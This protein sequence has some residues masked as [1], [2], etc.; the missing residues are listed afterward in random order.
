MNKFKA[1]RKQKKMSQIDVA[2]ALNVHQTTVSQWELGKAY[3]DIATLKAVAKLYDT[4]VN[5]LIDDDGYS[6]T[7]EFQDYSQQDKVQIPIYGTIPAGPPTEAE[8]YIIEYIEIPA[9]WQKGG[10]EYFGL[11][12]RGDSMYPQFIEGDIVILRRQ[13]N[14]EQ[15]KPHAVYVNGYNATLKKVTISQEG[16]TLT[17][18]NT[19]YSPRTYGPNDDPVTVCGVVVES[20]R[21]F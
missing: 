20:R 5:Y 1:L 15:G 12:V 21:R 17:P 9:E 8:Q 13:S 4:N 18:A 6:I 19:N 3:P 2:N 7:S 16:I 10:K 11:I 14:I